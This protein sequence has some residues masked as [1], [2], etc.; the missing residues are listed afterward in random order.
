MLK[1]VQY[2]VDDKGKKTA[3]ILNLLE[4][5]DYWEDLQDIL[6][7]ESRMN[8]STISWDELKSEMISESK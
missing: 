5:G 3:V 4:W 7:S 1:G 2:V 8:E 6:V